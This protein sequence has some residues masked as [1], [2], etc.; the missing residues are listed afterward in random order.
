VLLTVR[1]SD[2]ARLSSGYVRDTVAQLRLAG[3]SVRVANYN[4][5]AILYCLL[6]KLHHQLKLYTVFKTDAFIKCV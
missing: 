5:C 3:I 4:D 2:G 1:C 6:L